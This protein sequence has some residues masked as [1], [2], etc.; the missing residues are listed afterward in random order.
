VTWSKRAIIVAPDNA[1]GETDPEPIH[2]RPF[3]SGNPACG[4]VRSDGV[5]EDLAVDSSSGPHRGR[6]YDVCGTTRTTRSATT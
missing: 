5:I 2:C 6:I 3:I 1:I 4:I